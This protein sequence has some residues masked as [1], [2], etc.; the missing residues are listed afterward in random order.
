[1]DARG[2]RA[3][4]DRDRAA[5]FARRDLEPAEAGH[6]QDGIAHGVLA[7]L[8]PAL[9]PQ[10]VGGVRA[11]DDLEHLRELLHAR[12]DLA[13]VLAGAEHDVPGAA[14]AT[15]HAALDRAG[16]PHG[17]ADARHDQTD[18]VFLTD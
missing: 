2:L 18:C 5:D 8:R 9:A 13:I 17:D 1:A 3:E 12:R 14:A 15:F 10:I 6:R 11:V 4:V 16:L 7:E